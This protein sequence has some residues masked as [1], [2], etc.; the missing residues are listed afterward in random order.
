MLKGFILSLG[1]IAGLS[2]QANTEK[3]VFEN[4]LAKEQVAIM[5][6]AETMGLNWKVGDTC[7]YNMNM[8]F[9]NGTMIMSVREISAE[10]IWID[11]KADLGFLGKQD[12]SAL[13]DPNTGAIKKIIVNGK[14]QAPPESDVEL[15]DTAEDHIT[16]PAGSFDVIHFRIKDKKENKEINQWVN[17]KLI[18]LSGMVKSQSPAQFGDVVLELTSFRKN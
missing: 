18:P 12:M 8:G 7:N 13:I 2:A 5:A 9:I 1:L 17:P 11:Q 15:I 3:S 6:Q 4:V 10:G 16:V 14:E